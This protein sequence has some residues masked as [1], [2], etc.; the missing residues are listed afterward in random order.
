MTQF[1]QYLT[2]C[3]SCGANTSK[4]Y[5][6]EHEGCCKGCVAGIP[7]RQERILDAGYTA[8]AREEGHYDIPDNA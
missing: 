7:T 1:A 5:A 8:Y 3:N 6:R 2:R 4:K